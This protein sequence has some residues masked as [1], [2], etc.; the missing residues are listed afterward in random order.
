[1][2][3]LVRSNV[4]AT[5]FTVIGIMCK[6]TTVVLNYFYWDKHATEIGIFCLLL[7]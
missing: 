6:I 7:W 4:S 1:L 5:T 2:S 3:F